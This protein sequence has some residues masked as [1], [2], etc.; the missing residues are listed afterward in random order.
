MCTVK[1]AYIPRGTYSIII[2]VFILMLLL[3]STIGA[4]VGLEQTFFRVS[5]GVGVVELCANVSF[6]A[7][8]CPIAFPFDVQL[9]TFDGSAGTVY[10][11]GPILCLK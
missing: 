2:P 3:I 8:D 4:V 10:T 1:N 9:S 5:E 7:I 11:P 6:P